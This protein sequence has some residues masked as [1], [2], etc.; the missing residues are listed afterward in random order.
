MTVFCLIHALSCIATRIYEENEYQRKLIIS[1]V[2][3]EL[4][5]Y[6]KEIEFLFKELKGLSLNPM[7]EEL[8]VDQQLLLANFEAAVER[9][10][11]KRMELRSF[12]TTPYTLAFFAGLRDGL[13]AYGA[14]ASIMFAVGTILILTSTPFPPALLI[15]CITIGIACL[16]VFILNSLIHTYRHHVKQQQ[17]LDLPHEELT[18]IGQLFKQAKQEVEN[19]QTE[20]I[21]LTLIEG[22]EIDSSPQFFFQE[23]FEVI[24]S[25]F[26][27]M[28][29][30]SKAVDYTMNPLQEADDE[31]HYHDTPVMLVV[32]ALSS[33]VY[34]LALALRA[35][36]RSFGRLPLDAPLEVKS[37]SGVVPDVLASSN[38]PDFLLQ[39]EKEANTIQARDSLS[40]L[41]SESSF[42]FGKTKRQYEPL[43]DEGLSLS[44]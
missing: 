18:K 2:K 20:Q 27:G 5:S 32:T 12:S 28:G 13:A 44:T 11:N 34:A 37:R 21:K 1:Q 6:G 26:S 36:S 17:E 23:W 3:I 38:E 42:F 43:Q 15:T 4:C 9:F 10:K 41:R 31:G 24:R 22:M 14:L 7:N 8:L 33:I 35:Y 16:F 39:E 40:P 19:L 29:K 25:F 30:G